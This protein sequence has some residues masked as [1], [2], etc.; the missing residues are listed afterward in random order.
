MGKQGK[1]GAKKPK[2]CGIVRL[3]EG[4]WAVIA[5]LETI[6]FGPSLL[7]GKEKARQRRAS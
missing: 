2:L 1:I 5:E 3:L 4:K 7:F 6:E